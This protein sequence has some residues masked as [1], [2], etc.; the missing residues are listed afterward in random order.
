VNVEGSHFSRSEANRL[1]ILSSGSCH[2]TNAIVS[3]KYTSKS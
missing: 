1:I 3:N 2:N